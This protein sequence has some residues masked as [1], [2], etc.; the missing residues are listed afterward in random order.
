MPP[1][2]ATSCSARLHTNSAQ[3]TVNRIIDVFPTN[4]QD[5]IRTQ[6]STSIIGVLAQGLV[7]KIG[8]GRIACYEMLVV[9]P[10][11]GNLIREN[12]TFRITSAIQTGAK[13]GMILMDDS[14]FNLWREGKCAKEEVLIKAH[15]PDEL[16]LRI[17]KAERGIFED[18]GEAERAPSATAKMRQ[19]LTVPAVHARREAACAVSEVECERFEL[20]RFE[21]DEVFSS[22]QSRWQ[23]GNAADRPDPGRLGL[24]QRRPIGAI[25]RGAAAAAGPTA[26][27][28]GRG[29]GLRHRRTAGPGTGRTVGHAGHSP[30]RHRRSAAGPG[31]CHRADGPAL[32]DRAGQFSRRHADD[33]RLRSAE[34]H[35]SGRAAHLLGLR[36][37]R[38]RGHRT[39]HRRRA[40]TAIIRPAARAS[41]RSW[42][43]WKAT[44]SWPTWP[45]WSIAT[46]RSNWAVSRPRPTPPRSASCST[47]S[48][49]WR[50]RTRPPTCTSSRSRT[51][52][53]S[54]SRPTACCMKWSRRRGI[55]PSPL[56]P[57]SRSWPS[58]TSPSAACR[59][60]DASS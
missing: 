11:I 19:A 8:G 31:L 28:S 16:N 29:P 42:P 26:G 24:H 25:A 55:W 13:Y 3:G 37:P 49:C 30:G 54:A 5:Q 53:A 58:S 46:G 2:P 22:E 52:F 60:T 48:S 17:A 44:K 36:N 38:G 43:T 57:A 32:S 14:L 23:Y 47:W 34:S 51:N 40:R 6:L 59:R 21:C 39:R 18:E 4:Q 50:S 27:Q 12:K 41:S 9:T 45:K 20:W 7:P 35:R 10:A 15:I 33:R 1:K 56:P